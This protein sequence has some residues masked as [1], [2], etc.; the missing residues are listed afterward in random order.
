MATA[1]ELPTM[2]GLLIEYFQL[3]GRIIGVLLIFLLTL[4][5]VYKLKYG[6]GPWNPTLFNH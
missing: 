3:L 6:F 1:V 2:A 4:V 5:V